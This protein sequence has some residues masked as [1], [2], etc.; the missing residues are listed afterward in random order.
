MPSGRP[1]KPTKLKILHGTNRPDRNPDHEPEPETLREIPK[2]PAGMNRWARALWKRVAAQLVDL[3]ML[4]EL[5]LATL[6][7]LCHAYGMFS[8]CREAIYHPRDPE[9]GKKHKRTLAQYLAGQNSQTTPE[10]SAMKSAWQTYR[11]Y[12]SGFGFD[13]ASRNRINVPK[14]KAA[15]AGT[16][17][18]LL[19]AR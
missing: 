12:M 19:D 15:G 16:M 17:V 11:A 8:E 18:R 2:P 4:S 1:R 6:E 3:K 9:T 14:P 7:M 13:P 5:D 10:L